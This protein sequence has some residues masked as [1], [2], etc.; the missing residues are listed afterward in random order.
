MGS[1]SEEDF[2]KLF[3]ELD[4]N[5][6]RLGRT[7]SQRNELIS[8][9]L[10]H[11]DKIDFQ[12][13]NSQID[14]LGD[15]YEYLIG[16]FASG[17]GKKAGEFYTPQE[18]SQ[19]LARIVTSGKKELKSVYDPTCGSGSLLLRVAKYVKHVDR[20]F[21]QELNNTTYNLARM[22]MILHDVHYGDFDIKQEDTLE[23]PQ[24]T[25]FRFEAIVAN[26][27]FSAKWSANPIHLSDERFSQY[28]LLAP[29]KPADYAFIQHM[30]YQL[31]DNGTMA[32]VMP[33]GALNRGRV[34]AKI[35][36][37]LISERNYLDAVIG[38]PGNIFFGTES[39]A[40]IMIFKKCRTTPGNILFIDAS[41]GFDNS[42]TKNRLRQQDIDKI[43]SA[44]TA[45]VDQ[46][47]YSCVASVDQVFENRFNLNIPRYIDR[48][49][50]REILNPNNLLEELQNLKQQR[51]QT[52][53]SITA[54]CKELN[55]KDIF[56]PE[57]IGIFSGTF[58]FKD[59]T[60]KV[61]PDWQIK[62][63]GEITEKVTEKNSANNITNVLTNSAKRGI[64]NQRDYFDKD[65]AKQSNLTGYYVVKPDDFIYNPRI[66]ATAP[67]G[68][69]K[70]NHLGIGVMSPLYSIFRFK[71]GSN[72]TFF[73]KYFETT[74]WHHY[75]RGVAN[76]GAR[77]DRMSISQE[78]ILNI[79]VPFPCPEEQK[80]I[81]DFFLEIDKNLDLMRKELA[82][83]EKI[84][85]SLF[86]RMFV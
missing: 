11:L 67:V 85:K 8:K 79:P 43:I 75:M 12:L 73:E 34:E 49:E 23:H 53:K 35:R 32:V 77:H 22:N 9:V 84:K 76:Y 58:R 52:E 40:C 37:F 68:P 25:E 7:V 18:V 6:S 74:L 50:D 80:K 42:G 24:H 57:A 17:A 78:D 33:H 64:V 70:R 16:Q 83:M 19:I 54:C 69:I 45:R 56:T 62:K 72:L 21:G 2:E 26:P 3:S 71:R 82:Q 48:L 65:I 86:Q 81:A 13:E 4:L 47:G 30:L 55:A 36:K 41:Q 28:G 66:S 5:A 51:M 44:Y 59:D 20:F 29:K 1:D 38:L 31:D 15:A 10:L 27:P 60:G 63:L 39:P 14:V 46:A 61:F